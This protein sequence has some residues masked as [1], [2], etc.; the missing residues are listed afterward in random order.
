VRLEQDKLV[1]T[2]LACNIGK[3]PSTSS[4][5]WRLRPA[6]ASGNGA[7]SEVAGAAAPA[8]VD[9]C[10][11]LRDPG[12]TAWMVRFRQALTY[13]CRGKEPPLEMCEM[14]VRGEQRPNGADPL[15]E[16]AVCNA[17]AYWMTGIGVIE[18][19]QTCADTPEEGVGHEY[20][21][22]LRPGAAEPAIDGDT[23]RCFL[24][25]YT[26][27]GETQRGSGNLWLCRDKFPSQ[28]MLKDVANSNCPEEAK[29]VITGWTEFSSVADYEAFLEGAPDRTNARGAPR[30]DAVFGTGAMLKYRLRQILRHV[31]EAEKE[32]NLPGGRAEAIQELCDAIAEDYGLGIGWTCGGV[33]TPLRR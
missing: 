20:R 18:A 2:N 4:W 33:E 6:N 16:W 31:N 27:A 5:W 32:N 26:W 1:E 8:A 29:I 28:Q 12:P 22:D 14:W 30:S 9:R 21:E 19:A 17:G 10:G 25:A 13:L 23:G 15:Q 3:G 7:A 11:A 24:F